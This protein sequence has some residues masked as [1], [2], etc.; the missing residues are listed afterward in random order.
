M[1]AAKKGATVSTSSENERGS[2]IVE[3]TTQALHQTPPSP[4]TFASA[5]NCLPHP[6]TPTGFNLNFCGPL[7]HPPPQVRHFLCH[8]EPVGPEMTPSSMGATVL[9]QP[10]QVGIPPNLGRGL[11]EEEAERREA[12]RLEA[13]EE[14]EG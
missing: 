4:S 2:K 12:Y 5:S 13:G 9:V 14:A 6:T 11:D 3:L 1:Q 10:A 7:P 8:R